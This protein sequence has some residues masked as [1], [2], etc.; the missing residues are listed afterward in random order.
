M[1]NYTTIFRQFHIKQAP[2]TMVKSA[3]MFKP[4]PTNLGNEIREVVASRVVKSSKRSQEG[5]GLDLEG[6]MAPEAKRLF[7]VILAH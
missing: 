6:M 2:T 4:H 3:K 5:R 7:Q 1:K